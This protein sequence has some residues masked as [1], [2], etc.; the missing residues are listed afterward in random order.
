MPRGPFRSRLHCQRE[1]CRARS[2]RGLRCALPCSEGYDET[3][4]RYRGLKAGQQIALSA[5][6]PTGL[7][8]KP[9]A[10]AV[11]LE[12]ERRAE[13]E[14]GVTTGPR[15]PAGGVPGGPQPSP[16]GPVPVEPAPLRRFHGVVELDPIRAG[17][18]AGRIAQEVIA[19]LCALPNAQVHVTLEIE[20][21]V[22]GGVP[23]QVVRIV[24][25]NSRTLK[26]ST[27][28]FEPE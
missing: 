3:T 23:E 7:V 17:A 15:A 2:G 27:H 28:G 4:G 20:A 1:E 24:T 10:A 25:E 22:P 11:Q 5:D 13:G 18:D 14:G 19:H 8:V 26:F 6:N 21:T 12:R 16:V 9:D